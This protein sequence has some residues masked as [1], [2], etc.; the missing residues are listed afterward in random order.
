MKGHSTTRSITLC[1]SIG[2]EMPYNRHETLRFYRLDQRKS[3]EL[4]G[5]NKFM[6][7]LRHRP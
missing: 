3:C 7:L 2:L 1:A 4:P 6:A 5:L